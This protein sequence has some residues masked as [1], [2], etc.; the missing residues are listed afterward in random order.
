MFSSKLK[1]TSDASDRWQQC[2]GAPAATAGFYGRDITAPT[3]C[4]RENVHE[5]QSPTHT[6]ITLYPTR[7]VAWIKLHMLLFLLSLKNPAFLIVQLGLH[8]EQSTAFLISLLWEIRIFDLIT[9]HSKI[10]LF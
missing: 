5:H 8:A 2:L 3:F 10:F 9:F 6:Y 1:T 7:S 4:C